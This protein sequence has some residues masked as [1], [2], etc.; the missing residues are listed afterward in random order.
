MERIKKFIKDESGIALTEYIV[1]G[2]MI[3]GATVV[4][5]AAAGGA[6]GTFFDNMK[7]WIDAHNTF[8]G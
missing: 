1:L 6:I 2:A 8:G 7:T 3:V 4:A 5:V